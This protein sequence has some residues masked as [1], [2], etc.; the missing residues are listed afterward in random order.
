MEA[1]VRTLPKGGKGEVLIKY[2]EVLE[3]IYLW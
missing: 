2:R 3:P 1:N